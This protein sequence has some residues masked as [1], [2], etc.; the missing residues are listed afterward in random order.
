MKFHQAI[1]SGEEVAVR[2]SVLNPKDLADDGFKLNS[3]SHSMVTL[4][5]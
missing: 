3:L 5:I 4:P 2:F 1:A